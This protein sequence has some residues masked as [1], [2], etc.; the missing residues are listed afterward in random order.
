[1]VEE[2]FDQ[3]GGEP[4]VAFGDGDEI[5][6]QG[7]KPEFRAHRQRADMR[8]PSVGEKPRGHT[9][10]P[11][12]GRMDL[13]E[14]CDV[15]TLASILGCRA[16]NLVF[17]VYRRPQSVQYKI[18]EIPKKSGGMRKICA[19]N[20]NISMIQ[21]SITQELEKLRTFSSCVS[22]FVKGRNIKINAELHIGRKFVFNIDLEDFFTSITL[23]RI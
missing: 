22:G 9:F 1:M 19:P 5:V 14:A 18:F 12:R 7:V 13:T 17:Y 21:R 16:K 10:F 8:G 11:G 2:V 3:A 4:D 15:K 6:A 23:P 20:S